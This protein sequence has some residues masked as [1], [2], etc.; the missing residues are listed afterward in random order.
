[1][2]RT[3]EPARLGRPGHGLGAEDMPPD[4]DAVR[5]AV[6][7]V[8]TDEAVHTSPVAEEP[9][10]AP[11]RP[12]RGEDDGAGPAA[13]L[14]QLSQ[15]RL[16]WRRFRRHRAALVAVVVLVLMYLVALF[17]GFFAPADPA[18]TS[19]DHAF[20][21]PQV[22]HVSLSEGAW[23]HPS[24]GVTDP[25]TMA[26]VFTEDTSRRIQL[27]FF[28]RGDSYDILGIVHADVHLFGPVDAAERWYPL[29]ADRKGADLASRIIFGSQVSLSIGLIGVA[30][31]LVL[32]LVLGGIS[33]Y[34]GGWVDN[35]VQRVIEFI[36]SIPT[37][38]LWLSLAA[39]IPPGWGAVQTYLM[40]TVILSLIG[41]TSLARVIRGRFLQTRDEDF[42]LAARL[43]GVSTP[44][45][46]GRHLVPSFASHI[47]ATVSL[48]IPAMILA[49]TSLSFLGLGL[50]APAVSWGVLLQDAQNVQTVATAPW[51]MLPGIAVVLAVVAFNFVGDG[52]RDSADPYDN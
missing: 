52:L 21:P 23:V 42:V 3:G 4:D 17:A 6:A 24:V 30:V 19:A 28:V 10:W 41:W 15:S 49:E 44:R 43:D 11:Q 47:I 32:G 20:Q 51:L 31:S 16:I 46:I 14:A 27:G 7:G 45:I 38:P 12:G 13:P 48:A 39:A 37:L 22:P 36:M 18:A 35:V 50:R 9:E 25:E 26:R 34:F 29:G 40:I 1:M 8:E 2:G 5:A 33:G